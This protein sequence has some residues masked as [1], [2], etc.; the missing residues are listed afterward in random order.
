M[1][2]KNIIVAIDNEEYSRIAL[3]FGVMIAKQAQAVLHGVYVKEVGLWEGPWFNYSNGTLVS[4]PYAPTRKEYIEDTLAQRARDVESYFDAACKYAEVAATFQIH[5]GVVTAVVQEVS[6]SADLVIIGRRGAHASWLKQ[7][8]GSD[9][10][11]LLNR[12]ERPLMVS[13]M[14]P[15]EETKRI[16]LCYG[17]GDFAGKS[18]AMAQNL[19]AVFGAQ[20]SVLTVGTKKTR[21]LEV[22]KQAK[23][24][25]AQQKISATYILSA[26]EAS[27][28][29]MR[30]AD[31][32]QPDMLVIGA[33]I[34]SGYLDL[35]AP[36]VA[37]RILEQANYPVLFVR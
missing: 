25:F 6:Q 23:H 7:L 14:C 36:S 13:G 28:E 21:A 37:V 19:L 27:A 33:S 11:R 20:L 29:I 31:M 10:A 3:R 24:Y 35:L 12:V 17:G 5:T 2:F 22:Q 1:D 34:Q 32:E 8:L 16:L 18:L 26:G 4:E 30:V 9:C 15:P